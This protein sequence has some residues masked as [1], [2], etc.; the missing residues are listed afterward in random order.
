MTDIPDLEEIEDALRQIESW[1]RSLW[2]PALQAELEELA[3]RAARTLLEL[4]EMGLVRIYLDADGYI[5]AE[6]LDRVRH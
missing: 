6:M 1:P 3:E 2:P 4:R 5:A